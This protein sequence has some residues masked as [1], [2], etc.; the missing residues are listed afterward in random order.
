MLCWVAFQASFPCESNETALQAAKYRGIIAS[1]LTINRFGKDLVGH[2]TAASC[3]HG[4]CS[5]VTEF[6]PSE[7][8][9]ND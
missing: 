5:L 2:V 8:V 9:E 7:K 4:K 1:I 6:V 3:V